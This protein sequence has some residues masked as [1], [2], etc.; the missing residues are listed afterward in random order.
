MKSGPRADRPAD[1][2]VRWTCESDECPERKRRAGLRRGPAKP[3]ET[4]QWIVSSAERAE[5]GRGAGEL[6]PRAQAPYQT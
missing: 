3:D 6:P 4:I 1:E 2:Q 5:L